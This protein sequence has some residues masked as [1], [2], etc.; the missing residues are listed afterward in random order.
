MY[1]MYVAFSLK[2]DVPSNA[3]FFLFFSR[4]EKTNFIDNELVPL[5]W[6]VEIQKNITATELI[7]ELYYISV[8]RYA[9]S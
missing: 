6:S 8:L 2:L 5:C 4:Y 1:K 3:D 9:P 7:N